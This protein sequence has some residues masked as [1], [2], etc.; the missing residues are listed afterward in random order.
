V[1]GAVARSLLVAFLATSTICGNEAESSAKDVHTIDES[2]SLLHSGRNAGGNAE[3]QAKLVK[4]ALY[5]V[6]VFYSFFIM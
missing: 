5:A 2:S 6:Q 4:A 3:Q 1:L